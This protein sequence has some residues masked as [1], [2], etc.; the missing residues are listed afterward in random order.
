MASGSRFLMEPFP[1]SVSHHLYRTL[2]KRPRETVRT[3]DRA[4]TNPAA[5]ETT[6]PSATSSAKT[7]PTVTARIR[8]ACRR[9]RC[10]MGCG[11]SESTRRI[12]SRAETTLVSGSVSSST[13]R[14]AIASS[15]TSSSRSRGESSG[16]ERCS[17]ESCTWFPFLRR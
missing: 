5:P 2:R 10:V 14:R 4:N 1:V 6:R 12:R 8:E 13:R 17:I 3:Q 15:R 11:A 9:A 7:F 16:A